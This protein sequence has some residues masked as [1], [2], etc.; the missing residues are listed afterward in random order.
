MLSNW[1]T[2]QSLLSDLRTCTIRDSYT[3]HLQ[4]QSPNALCMNEWN[5]WKCSDLKCIQ[6]PGVGLV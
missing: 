1:I 4:F 6:K 5:E 3:L 2:K